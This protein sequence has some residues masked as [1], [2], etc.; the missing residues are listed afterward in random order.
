MMAGRQTPVL[1]REQVARYESDGYLYLEDA[2]T[3]ARLSLLREVFNGWVDESRTHEGPYG[4]TF[5][6][7]PRFDV[8]PGHSAEHPALRRV[9]SPVEVS[10]A[11]LDVMRDNPALDAVAQLIGPNLRFRESKVNSKLAGT[12]THLKFHQDLPF[13]PLTNE[14]LVTVLFHLDDV[15]PENGPLEVVPGSHRGPL[16]EHWHDGIFTGAVSPEVAAWAQEQVVTC[17]GAAG[18]AYLMNARVLHGSA[19]NLSDRARSLFIVQYHAEDAHP[20]APNHLPSRFDQ[21]VVVGVDTGRVR[22]SD[23]EVTIPEMPS[24]ASFFTVQAVGK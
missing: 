6:G 24:V 15:T 7:R 9:A 2:L 13:G 17:C 4:E 10:D 23:Y 16:Y 19:P 1:D 22:C 20:L 5:D 12:A 8:E 21:E 14:D 11:Y 3:P 18:S